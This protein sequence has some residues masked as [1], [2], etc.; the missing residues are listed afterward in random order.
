MNIF[1]ILTMIGGL[2]MFLYGMSVMGGGLEKMSGGK[3]ER[4][5]ESLT[6]NPFKAVL[7]GAGVTAVIQSSSATTVMVVGFV[8]SGMMTLNQ[9]VWIIMGANIG[10]TITA[11]ILSLAG[12]ESSNFFVKL[13]NPSSFSPILALVGVI[14]IVFLHN[15][16]PFNMDCFRVGNVPHPNSIW[17]SRY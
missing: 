13:L 10:T 11:W 8:N 17:H 7:L 9:A 1:G 12:I 5:L 6:S 15:F 4:I 2:A 14:F 3:L 16:S